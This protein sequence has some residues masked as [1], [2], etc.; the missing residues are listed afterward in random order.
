MD[1]G[2]RGKGRSDEGGKKEKEK[3]RERAEERDGLVDT[4]VQV[5]PSLVRTA[6]LVTTQATCSRCSLFSNSCSS[7]SSITAI[8][9]CPST[10]SATCYS[11]NYGI[12]PLCSQTRTQMR[13]HPLAADGTSPKPFLRDSGTSR[14]GKKPIPSPDHPDH[15]Q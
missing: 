9:H 11:S 3:E 10:R 15:P 13:A 8:A 12:W 2:G 1:G 5:F 4:Y 14:Q 6:D 7:S